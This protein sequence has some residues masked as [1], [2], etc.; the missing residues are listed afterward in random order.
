MRAGADRDPV[1]SEGRTPL[2]YASLLEDGESMVALL[3]QATLTDTPANYDSELVY[4]IAKGNFLHATR[5]CTNDSKLYASCCEP[6]TN[7]FWGMKICTPEILTNGALTDRP[8]TATTAAAAESAAAHLHS[9]STHSLP[10]LS[11]SAP[12][13]QQTDDPSSRV[14][15]IL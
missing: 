10:P 1:D 15:T 6:R 14:C 13:I 7:L 5:S 4:T 12:V 9:Y 3:Q 8:Q 11:S 2:D